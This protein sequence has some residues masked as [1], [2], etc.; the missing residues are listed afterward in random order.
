MKD[1][2]EGNKK[3]VEETLAKDPGF[4]NNLSQGQTPEYL[5][6]G[7]SDSRVPANEIVNLPPGSI[8]VQR[9][10]ANQVINS[11]MNLLSVV[12]YAVKYLR[13]KHILI[14]GH[15]GCGGVAAAMSNNSFGF[16]DNWLVSIKNVYL[17][18][19][20]ELEAITDPELRTDRLV[21]LN[22]IQQAVN[23]AKISFIQEEWQ[24]GNPLEIHALV[25]SLKDGILRDMKASINNATDLKPVFQFYQF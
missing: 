5:W 23:M 7:C 3:W 9:N 20:A 4:F 6:I 24:Q 18:N 1:I 19:Q 15:Y 13:V 17:K 14:V 12:Y 11:D 21:E 25:Y 10:I 16:L 22:A 8:F 2:F